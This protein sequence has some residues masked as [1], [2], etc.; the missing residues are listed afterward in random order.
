MGNCL[1]TAPRLATREELGV[2]PSLH[3]S[4]A[5]HSS[6]REGPSIRVSFRDLLIRMDGESSLSPS[7]FA[8]HEVDRS[9]Y[10][11]RIA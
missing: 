3:A 2:T 1:P 10:P 9:M 8:N 7:W 11:N 4:P 6:L 5:C